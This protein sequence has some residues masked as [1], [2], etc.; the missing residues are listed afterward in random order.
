MTSNETTDELTRRCEQRSV[1]MQGDT[2]VGKPRPI[3]K[4]VLDEFMAWTRHAPMFSSSSQG[5]VFAEEIRD[6]IAMAH[7]WLETESER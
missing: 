3:T 5:R 7:M 2:I 1:K 6:V 4:E